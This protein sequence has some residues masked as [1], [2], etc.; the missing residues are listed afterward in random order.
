MPK[1]TNKKTYTTSLDA[2]LISEFKVYCAIKGLY[3]NEVL[4]SLIRELLEKEKEE[5]GENGNTNK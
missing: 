1:G 2:D 4:E 5:G 3:Q